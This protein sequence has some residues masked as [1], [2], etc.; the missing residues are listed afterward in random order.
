V[1]QY[2][3]TGTAGLLVS[4][5]AIIKPWDWA[6][7]ARTAAVSAIGERPVLILRVASEVSVRNRFLF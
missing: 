7:R 5:A 6:D 2:L 3:V 1:C 4:I